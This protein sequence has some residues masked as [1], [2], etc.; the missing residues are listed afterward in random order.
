MKLC[1][2]TDIHLNFPLLKERK[3]FYK[4]IVES[5][6]DKILIS[7]DISESIT[8][9]EHLVEM[10]KYTKKPIYFVLGNHDYYHSSIYEVTRKMQKLQERQ[11]QLNWLSLIEPIQLSEDVILT[12]VD[13]WADGGYGDFFEEHPRS[14]IYMNDSILIEELNIARLD[15]RGELLDVMSYYADID[16][17]H[18]SNKILDGIDKF[19]PKKILILSHIPPFKESCFEDKKWLPFYSCKVIGD[20]LL[21]KSKQNPDIEFLVLCGHTHSKAYY[22]PLDNLIVKTGAA[23]YHIPEIQEIIEI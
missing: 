11:S 5:S 17:K 16:A 22:K 21:E 8:I 12:G 2:L 4:T 15:G 1:W 23:K 3:K 19:K 10:K 20:M 14:Q 18:L 7:G 13:G 9:E 6:C